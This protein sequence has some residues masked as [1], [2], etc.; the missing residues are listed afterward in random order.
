MNFQSQLEN[1][2]P[3]LK[4][5]AAQHSDEFETEEL[6]Q[7]AVACMINRPALLVGALRSKGG[8]K[9]SAFEA[10]RLRCRQILD[11]HRGALKHGARLEF[12]RFVVNLALGQLRLRRDRSIRTYEHLASEPMTDDRVFAAATISEES[13]PEQ[14]SAVLGAIAGIKT[15]VRHRLIAGLLRRA[16][17]SDGLS[18]EDARELFGAEADHPAVTELLKQYDEADA[19]NTDSR[20]AT[21]ENGKKGR[22]AKAVKTRPNAANTLNKEYSLAKKTVLKALQNAK[23]LLILF[24]L[25]LGIGVSACKLPAAHLAL[26]Q[27]RIE[28]RANVHFIR[29]KARIASR[30]CKI[31]GQESVHFASRQ[32]RTNDLEPL[33]ASRQCRAEEPWIGSRAAHHSLTS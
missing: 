14:I 8:L 9:R 29:D 12:G 20:N 15:A 31:D 22:T 13:R 33:Y 28:E 25:V 7:Q 6:V 10:R 18:L 23:L 19:A 24:A 21:S 17:R 2:V 27:C 30:Q 3:D 1:L 4:L 16:D 5:E 32:C 11:F 26:R